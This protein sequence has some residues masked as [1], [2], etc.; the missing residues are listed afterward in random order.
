MSKLKIV[1]QKI[2]KLL[3][4]F[5]DYSLENPKKVLVR[6]GVFYLI[7][8]MP[9]G[10]FIQPPKEFPLESI[11]N[12]SEGSTLSQTARHLKDENIIKSPFFFKALTLITLNQKNIFAGDYYFYKERNLFTIIKRVTTGKFNLKL[13]SVTIPEG[14]TINEIAQIFEKKF[15]SFNSFNFLRIV[16]GKEGYLFPDTYFVLP[17][18][19]AGEVAGMMEENFYEKVATIESKIE[20]FGKPLE[21]IIIMASLLEEEARTTETRRNIADVL[22]KRIDI[23]MPLQVDAVFS[24]IKGENIP[25]V[26]LE[27]LKVDSPYNTYLYKG[28]PVGPIS[29]PGLD[30]IL[31]AV[32]PIP[33]NYYYYLSDRSGNMHYAS[34]FE[35]HQLNRSLYLR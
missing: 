9:Y 12:I 4:S 19:K 7:I 3:K 18:V 33:N 10:L 2:Q 35:G 13:V 25:F 11:V 24:Y 30:S 31:S 28:L 16:K 26:S 23:G 1:L 5:L 21:E 27:D 34:T 15:S 32:T 8:A 14:A 22:W 17:N 6:L 29:N 20:A